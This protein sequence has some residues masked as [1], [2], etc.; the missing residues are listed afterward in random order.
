[1]ADNKT[2]HNS[3]PFQE[4]RASEELEN[5]IGYTFRDKQLLTEALTH[6]SY[7]NEK[8]SKGI[9]RPCNERLEFLGDSVLSILVSSYLFESYR[10]IQEGELTKIRAAVVCEKALSRFAARIELGQYMHMGH[11]ESM[12]NGRTRPSILADAFEALLAAMYLDAGENFEP[13]RTFLMPF[14]QEELQVIRDNSVFVDYKTTL[15][16]IVQ[17]VEGERLE[18]ILVGEAGP[19]HAKVFTVE[20]RL[21]SNVIGKGSARSKREAEQNAAKEALVLFGQK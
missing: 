2:T 7:S 16:Q 8:R 18:Y 21:N 1:M 19:D 17:Q 4:A 10:D 9:R 15:Q 6:S 12:N 11:G 20:A 13:A 14:I 3:K 5:A